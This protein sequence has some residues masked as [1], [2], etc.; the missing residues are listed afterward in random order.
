MQGQLL[1]A[2]PY[3]RSS[4]S[5]LLLFCAP[6]SSST[7]TTADLCSNKQMRADG[8]RGFSLSF[9][10]SSFTSKTFFFPLVCECAMCTF[11]YFPLAPS[12]LSH[13]LASLLPF[14]LIGSV[15]V[16]HPASHRNNSK[17]GSG[18]TGLQPV[19]ASFSGLLFQRGT[20]SPLLGSLCWQAV[21]P[22]IKTAPL[23]C[24]CC[25]CCWRA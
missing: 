17:L 8:R 21:T 14:F 18:Q 3:V 20:A 7:G 6:F 13:L 5:S 10:L 1:P 19:V 25:C 4:V 24:C 11:V 15:A 16:S 2:N 23:S 9:F 22:L 12:A